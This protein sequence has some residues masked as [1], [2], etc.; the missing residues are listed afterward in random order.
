MQYF[1]FRAVWGGVPQDLTPLT[2][3]ERTV[4][5]VRRVSSSVLDLL[6]GM[7]YGSDG[8]IGGDMM[9]RHTIISLKSADYEK[10]K[11]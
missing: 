11:P 1:A 8:S 6:A 10:R 3:E 7:D 9:R 5:L 4:D 2:S